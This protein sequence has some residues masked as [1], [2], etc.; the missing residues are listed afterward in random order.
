MKFLVDEC[1]S[2]ALASMARD[3]GYHES[4]HVNWLGLSSKPDWTIVRRAVKDGYIVVTNN[5][6]HFGALVRREELHAGLVCLNFPAGSMNLDIQKYLFSHALEHL[7]DSE[8]RGNSAAA[9]PQGPPPP[10]C[11]RIPQKRRETQ[12]VDNRRPQVPASLEE[13]KRRVF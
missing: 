2:P 10:E 3:W 5:T 11:R 12:S 7:D 6:E 9:C 8:P 13:G 1:V 4:T